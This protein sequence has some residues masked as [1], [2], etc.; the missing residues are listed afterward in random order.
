MTRS[1]TI[2]LVLAF[3]LVTLTSVILVALFAGQRATKEFDTFRIQQGKTRFTEDVLRYYEQ[4]DSW[5][6]VDQLFASTGPGN[7]RSDQEGGNR[8]DQR[9]DDSR[10]PNRPDNDDGKRPDG[11]P[12]APGSGGSLPVPFILVDTNHYVVVPVRPY[13]VGER[14]SREMVDQGTPL[15]LDGATIGTILTP[16]EAMSRNAQEEQFL[17]Q[18]TTALLLGAG[19]ATVIVLILG[20]VLA[21]T[22]TRPLREL[23]TAIQAM[24]R[25]DLQQEVPVRSKDELGN[26]AIA[27][28][29]MSAD[30]AR[31][32]QLRQQM[33]ADIAHDLRNPLTVLS[34]YLE[35]LREGVLDPSPDMFEVMHDETSHLQRLIE[36]LRTLSLA[37]ANELSLNCQMVSPQSFL[38][39][40]AISYEHQAQQKNIDIPV[41]V[42]PHLPNIYIDSERMAQVVGNLVSNALRYTPDAGK[43]TLAAQ[44]HGNMIWLK[45]ADNGI[46]IAA[47]ELPRIF[48]R[49]YRVDK[50]REHTDS[51]SGLGLAIAKSIVEA[52]GGNI[53]VD[54]TQGQGTTFT[55]AL[56]G[57]S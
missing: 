54:S 2:K 26:L 37:D 16:E 31:S 45:V 14:L 50:A 36:D 46:G 57:A 44:R 15:V 56:A 38:E 7:R 6:G 18:M 9:G 13:N 5:V 24:A 1:L 55:I 17:E 29:Q 41:I 52:H 8:S 11:P 48:D 27:F 35:A 28:N 32:N 49:A 39:R 51:Q 4:T 34:G 23:T 20:V 12:P 10:G 47:E 25:G 33:T 19:G 30:L 3:L 22:L 53:S 40:L 42:E 43:I 21:R